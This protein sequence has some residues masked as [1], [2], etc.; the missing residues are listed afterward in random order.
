[1][2]YSPRGHR[3]SDTAERLSLILGGETSPT[4]ASAL[5]ARP[6]WVPFAGGDSSAVGTGGG[7]RYL[8]I[9]PKH[10]A[11]PWARGGHRPPVRAQ[12]RPVSCPRRAF[13]TTVPDR[14]WVQHRGSG[15]TGFSTAAADRDS[16][17][18]PAVD[19]LPQ[20]LL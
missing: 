9:L 16:H 14:D 1:M 19:V 2:G 10:A 15:Q 7:V 11:R 5:P 13:S 6:I 18:L 8:S 3:E 12:P 20:H 4:A 17:G